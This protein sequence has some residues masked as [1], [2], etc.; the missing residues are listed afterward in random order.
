MGS[1]GT[2]ILQNDDVAD[3]LGEYKTFL[4]YGMEQNEA[5]EKVKEIFYDEMCE[6]GC[7]DSFWYAIADFEWKHGILSEIVKA[8][9][10]EMLDKPEFLEVW[11]ES[12]EKVYHKR[13]EA[14]RKFRDKITSEMPSRKRISKPSTYMRYKTK[15]KVGDLIAYKFGSMGTTIDYNKFDEDFDWSG[16]YIVFRVVRIGTRPVTDYYPELDHTTWAEIAP[17]NWVGD[18]IPDEADISSLELIPIYKPYVSNVLSARRYDVFQLNEIKPSWL[19]KPEIIVISNNADFKGGEKYMQHHAGF[20][21]MACQIETDIIKSLK[22]MKNLND[23]SIK[24][25]I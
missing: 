17:Y 14:L 7:E 19:T 22:I 2:G 21:A 12:E 9:A 1:W 10:L 24:V 25:M 18:H 6:C 23:Y 16:K 5:L 11:K 20:S 15:F 4:G 13:L 3:V 8:K